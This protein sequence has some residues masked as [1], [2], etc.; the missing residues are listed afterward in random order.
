MDKHIKPSKEELAAGAQAALDALEALPADDTPPDDTTP[1][2]KSGPD[3][4]KR[5]AD[6][7]R[8]AQ[9]LARDNKEIQQAISDAAT[10]P[11]PTDEDLIKEYPEWEDM[12][13]TEQRL[14][15]ESLLSAQRFN[16][17]NTATSKLMKSDE[18]SQKVQDF[19]DDVKVITNNPELDGFQ[20]EFKEFATHPERRNN[21]LS[22]L[23]LAFG[24]EQAKK[25]QPKKG[26]MF[27][28]G[29]GGGAAPATKPDDGKISAAEGRTL[30]KTDYKKFKQLLK[31][32]KIKNDE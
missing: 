32:G 28:T 26:H 17:L 11:T 10:L 23:I 7:S 14:A 13:P 4:K 5:Y 9:R 2:D 25:L 31:E 12:T 8:E 18:W 21:D 1:E 15:R 27:P 24:A 6:S 20:D 16:L 3:Y 19:V 22:T 29:Q 30:M